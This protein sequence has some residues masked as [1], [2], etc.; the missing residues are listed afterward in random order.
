MPHGFTKKST[1]VGQEA[2]R[3]EGRPKTE[4]LLEFPWERQGR[5]G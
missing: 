4:P 2:E 1:R 5:A 3:N